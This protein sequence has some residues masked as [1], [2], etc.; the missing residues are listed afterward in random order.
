V[1]TVTTPS[2]LEEDLQLR[3]IGSPDLFEA[4]GAAR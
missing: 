3:S 4:I 1:V 2:L